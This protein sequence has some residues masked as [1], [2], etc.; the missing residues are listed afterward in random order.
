MTSD[1]SQPFR[2]ELERIIRHYIR[3]D[4][5][6][7]LRIAD[8][9]LA[10]CI[11][12]VKTTT[13]PSALLPAFTAAEMILKSRS[14]PNFIRKSKRN[15][16]TPR[17]V[18]I[19]S[20]ASAVVLFGV[21]VDILLIMSSASPFWRVAS[22][23]VWWPGFTLLFAA[24]Q[25]ICLFL[26]AWNLQQLRPWEARHNA[27]GGGFASPDDHDG[28]G[29]PVAEFKTHISSD[30]DR[31]RAPS[32]MAA[33]VAAVAAGGSASSDAASRASTPLDAYGDPIRKPSMQAFGPAN[34]WERRARMG[35]YGASPT[36]QKIWDEAVRT[37]NRAARLLRDRSVLLAVCWG[38]ALSGLLTVASLW[39]PGMNLL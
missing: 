23:V 6:R 9:D 5:P 36:R 18:L 2:Q 4:A 38:G 7:R 16:N 39:I 20:I 21:F 19:R 35:V 25:G 30:N 24:I 13:H 14:H 3:G 15:A 17:L 27:T 10:E 8:E 12:A 26:Y 34:R 22:L 11:D 1:V 37:Q 29:L 33:A 31:R 32:R 28:D